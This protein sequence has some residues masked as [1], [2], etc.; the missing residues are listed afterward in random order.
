MRL[1]ACLF[2]LN[3]MAALGPLDLIVETGTGYDRISTSVD[4]AVSG[5]QAIAFPGEPQLGC[6]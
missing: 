6:R 1:V 2:A 5:D 4:V 3:R